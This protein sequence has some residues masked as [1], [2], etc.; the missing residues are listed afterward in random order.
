MTRKEA[1]VDVPRRTRIRRRLVRSA[2]RLTIWLVTIPAVIILVW[3]FQSRRK[4]DLQAWHTV[5]LQHEFS[6]ADEEPGTT[7]ADYLDRERLL[8]DELDRRVVI[9]G[10]VKGRDRVNRYARGS[11]AEP[12]RFERDWN[13]TF[14]LDHDDPRGGILMLHG[15]TDSPYSMRAL[16]ELFHDHGFY[17]LALRLPGHGTTPGELSRVHWEDWL[18]AARVAARHVRER[19]PADRPFFMAGYSNGGTLAVKYALDAID[20]TDLPFPERV[21]LFSPAIGVTA[22]ARLAE[23]HHLLSWAPY[24]EKFR[25]LSIFPEYDPFKYVSFPKNAAKQTFTLSRVTCDQLEAYQGDG[26]MGQL[27]PIVA[28]QSVVDSTV[29]ASD[30]VTALFDRLDENGSELILFDINRESTMEEFMGQTNEALLDQLARSSRLR[31]R[32]TIV[33]NERDSHEIVARDKRPLSP[34]SPDEDLPFEWPA[35]VYSLSHLAIPFPPDDPLYG[36]GRYLE[37]DDHIHLGEMDLRGERNVLRIGAAD[38]LRLRHNPFF[39]Y[40]RRRIVETLDE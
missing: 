28:F 40:Q 3:A 29:I 4:P 30:V 12:A 25:W 34:P 32:L 6:A 9:K 19:V 10:E 22:W 37:K 2:I 8:F 36:L 33:T 24:F 15:L 21:Y 18:A 23:V 38:M 13:R 7:L 5:E 16:A 31:Y 17:V 20:D 39:E 1:N 27:P 26:R 35:T 11:R 14:E